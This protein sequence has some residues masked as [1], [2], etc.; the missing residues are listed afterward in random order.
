M[1][2]SV[3]ICFISL[4]VFIYI[5]YNKFIST[6]TTT[7]FPKLYQT[8]AESLY[9]VCLN[10]F[11]SILGKNI[12]HPEFFIKIS[13]VFLFL[14]ISNVQGMIPYMNTLTSAL[15]NTF[16]MALALFISI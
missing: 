3:K 11:F 13:T 4:F 14:I 8:V 9:K 6:H 15:T 16:F 7:I 2:Y 10:L 5:I 12:S 1:K